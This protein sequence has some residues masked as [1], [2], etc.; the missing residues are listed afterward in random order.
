MTET[1]IISEIY[2]RAR[3]EHWEPP[4]KRKVVFQEQIRLQASGLYS[5]RIVCIGRDAKVI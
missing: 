5:Y 4:T 2:H 3:P 1:G